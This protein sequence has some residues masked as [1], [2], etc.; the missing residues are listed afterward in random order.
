LGELG[1]FSFYPT[2]NLGALGDAGAVVC[3]DGALFDRLKALHQYGWTERY[4]SSEP[5]GRNSRIDEIQAAALRVKLPLL[6][7]WNQERRR[8]AGAYAAALGDGK[9]SVV[10]DLDGDSVVHLVVVRS[11]NRQALQRHLSTLGI[12]WGVHFPVLDCDQVSQ[13]ELPYESSDL[14]ESRSALREIVTVPCFPGM[15]DGEVER[16]SAALSS[17][18]SGAARV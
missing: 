2:K 7:G 3:R 6:A 16:V 17:F 10:N 14:G 18:V 11:P 13:H 12:Q 1:V 15:T 5:F 4:F 9:V 8:I